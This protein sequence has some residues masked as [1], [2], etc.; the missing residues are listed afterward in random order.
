MRQERRFKNKWVRVQAR[1][2]KLHPKLNREIKNGTLRWLVRD[3][4]LDLLGAFDVWRQGRDLFVIG[5]QHRKLALE[6]LG[7][8]EW[9]VDCLVYEG[10]SLAEACEIALARNHSTP[11]SPYEKFEKG[12]TAGET[13]CLGVREL[14]ESLGL[15][16]AKTSSD[17]A[18]C[19]FDALRS[20]WKRDYGQTLN[21]ALTYELAA[22][23]HIAAGV[24][25]QM[26]RGFVE[27]ASRYNGEVD[28]A[29]LVKKLAKF[30]GGPSALLGQA[31]SQAKIKGGTVSRNL[32]TAI[33][34]LYN[35]GRRSGQLPPL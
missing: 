26:V 20:S 15:H 2:L 16:T 33:V 4:D 11:W 22:W 28:S 23:G 6:E 34:D 21:L 13:D 31:K 8:G 25:G 30:P 17:G 35:K 10:M 24:E 19:C 27:F 3:M 9:E 1:N 32:A 14:V 12:L 5:G 7:M 18:I 29:S